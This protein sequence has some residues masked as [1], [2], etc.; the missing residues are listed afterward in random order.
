MSYRNLYVVFIILLSLVVL[1][2]LK[3][4]R[5]F[6]CLWDKIY[7]VV[8]GYAGWLTGLSI[9]CALLLMVINFSQNK[10]LGVC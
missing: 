2:I 10:L 8:V 5:G 7:M 3:N 4:V 9:S 1:T 6:C